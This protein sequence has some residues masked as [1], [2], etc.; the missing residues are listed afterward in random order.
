MIALALALQDLDVRSP[1]G[2]LRDAYCACVQ[3]EGKRQAAGNAAPEQAAIAALRA[4]KAERRALLDDERRLATESIK[5]SDDLLR[6]ELK[7][8]IEQA[9]H[10]PH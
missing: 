7:Q 3:A 10:A 4:C 1:H 5:Q 8:E 9:R 6:S 2:G